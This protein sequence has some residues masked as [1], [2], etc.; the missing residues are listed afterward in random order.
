MQQFRLFDKI[1]KLTL[2]CTL[3]LFLFVSFSQNSFAVYEGTRSTSYDSGSKMCSLGEVKYDPLI[4]NVDFEWDFSNPVCLAF[5][6]GAGAT[7]LTLQLASFVACRPSF[8]YGYNESYEK[9]IESALIASPILSPLTVAVMG[10][11]TGQCSKRMAEAVSLE[12]ASTAACAPPAPVGC[13]AA[14]IAAKTGTI[15]ANVCCGSMAAHFA[16]VGVGLGVLAVT[17]ELADQAYQHDRICG[18]DW[19]EWQKDAEGDWMN[20]RGSRSQCVSDLFL[21]DYDKNNKPST[22]SGISVDG[23]SLGSK[24]EHYERDIEN[25]FYREFIYGGVEYKDK[26]SEACEN[27]RKFS[28]G[29]KTR[30]E[31][32]GYDDNKQRYYMTGAGNAAS[33]ACRRFVD[34]NP[35]S[36]T[37]KAFQCCNKRSQNTICF[38]G[39]PWDP[40]N[41]GLSEYEYKLCEIGQTC[42]VA[43]IYYDVYEGKEVN[44]Y[45]CAKTNTVCPY[46]H[47]V[48]G[49]T[50]KQDFH[51]DSAGNFVTKNFCQHLNHCQKLPI[52][53]YVRNSTM[54]GD[55]ISQTCKDM[56]GDSQNVYS[57]NFHIAGLRM[58]GFTAPIAQC[59]K[60]TIENVFLNRAGHSICSDPDEFPNKEGV[61]LSGY[62]L[63]KGAELPDKSFFIKI[64]EDVQDYVRMGLVFAVMAFG[65]G[66]LFAAPGEGITKKKILPFIVKIGLVI[67]FAIGTGW[68]DNFIDG[69]LQASSILSDIVFSIDESDVEEELDGCQ[70]PRFN[71]A[72]S[73]EETRYINPQYSAENKYLKIWDVLDCKIARALGYGPDVSV[74]NLIFMILG[75]FLVGGLGVIFF[76]STFFLA[77][78]LLS[79]AVRALQ[80]FLISITAVILLLYISPLIIPLALFEKT[81][82]IFTGW[83]K[84]LIGFTLQ[85]VVLF[86]YLGILIAV[87]DATIIG[88]ITFEGDGKTA[89]KKIVC[90]GEAADH[91]MYC[92][93]NVADI[94]TFT[95]LEPLGIGLP[96]LAGMNQAKL[97]YI[98]KTAIILFIYFQFMDQIMTFAKKLVGGSSIQ[99]SWGVKGIAEKAAG[100]LQGIQERGTRGLGKHGGK[101]ARVAIDAGAK[102]GGAAA[103]AAGNKGKAAFRAAI[104]GSKADE[105]AREAPKAGG[106][107]EKATSGDETG[108]EPDKDK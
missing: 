61:C 66:V 53:P 92:I 78:L 101:A 58:D 82:N 84:Q 76:L 26:G 99:S 83:W 64:Q 98:I 86:A 108:K 74:P 1:K 103:R 59:Y 65:I 60:E 56:K 20:V 105:G 44:N 41:T 85:P 100:A 75:G 46:N 95:G 35:D 72:D 2:S 94:K 22:C 67:Y 23:T 31:V 40:I 9:A 21:G 24:S 13:A 90:E 38:E 36:D 43:G 49:G 30:K 11:L 12:S 81:K 96:L 17:W 79:I 77:F 6:V 102:A 73:D 62:K 54:E 68:Q 5:T 15:V 106:S 8:A 51:E 88:D 57:Y 80:I 45:I 34:S 37:E 97:H 18:H 55:F 33:F 50:E 70:F 93:F 16:A 29:S 32:L 104:G 7:I 63:Q 28:A 25:R 14:Q 10:H 3:S 48:G 42:E 4:S 19:N 39:K 69:T 52:P 107:E 91:S 27:P 87:V 71:Y 47:L 89:P